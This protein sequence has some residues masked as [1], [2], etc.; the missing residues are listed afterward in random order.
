MRSFTGKSYFG[1]GARFVQALTLVFMFCLLNAFTQAQEA[2]TTQHFKMLSTV[3]FD[4]E[5]QHR[6]QVESLFTVQREPLEDDRVRYAIAASDFDLAATGGT[7]EPAPESG[8]LSFVVDRGT[9]QVSVNSQA[10]SFFEQVNNQCVKALTKVTKENVGKNWKQ[11]FDMTFLGDA[12]PET[13]TFKMKAIQ[14]ETDLVGEMIAVRALS[15]GFR[16]KIP[17]AESPGETATVQSRIGTVYLFDPLIETIY[18]SM[19]VFEARTK[20][21]GSN[22]ILRHEVAT[23]MTDES[24]EAMDLSGLGKSFESLV[25]KLKMKDQGLEVVDPVELPQ[26][27]LSEGLRLSQ[28]A[29]ISASVACEGA[30][31]PVAMV[32]L[33]LVQTVGLQ[34]FGALG[35]M[36]GLAMAGGLGAGVPGVA[37]MNFAGAP[38]LGMGLGPAAAGG[39]AAGGAAAIDNNQGAGDTSPASPF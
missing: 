37:G 17:N 36:G 19:S 31:N 28:M 22:E 33:P 18:M 5:G 16:C 2:A 23:Y 10:L 27:A 26:W 29:N 6:N 20:M 38:F 9:K 35:S 7:A 24:G 8:G 4:G 25:Q 12:F 11:T 39:A 32:S 15:D 21:S 3:E 1:R 13:L 30:S 34:S 14:L